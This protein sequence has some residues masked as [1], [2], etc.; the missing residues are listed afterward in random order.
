M[1]EKNEKNN[2]H[3]VFGMLLQYIICSSCNGRRLI[4]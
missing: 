4:R 1:K 3:V 2:K